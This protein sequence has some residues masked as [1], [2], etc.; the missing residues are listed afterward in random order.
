MYN[1]R[2]IHLF[3]TSFFVKK[4][5]YKLFYLTTYFCLFISYCNSQT[6]KKEENIFDSQ[7]E[8]IASLFKR[9]DNI[10]Y[11][12]AI[13]LLKKHQLE[14]EKSKDTSKILIF[15]RHA[16]DVFNLNYDYDYPKKYLKKGFE[17]LEHYDDKK[18]LGLFYELYGISIISGAEINKKINAY[19]VAEKLLCK[20][21]EPTDNIDINFNLSLSFKKIKQ[22][23]KVIIYSNKALLN[24]QKSKEKLNR[25][26]YLYFYLIEAYLEKKDYKNAKYYLDLVTADKALFLNDERL[27]VTYNEMLGKYF[28]FRGD[29]I[30]AAK[31]YD[32][33]I[34]ARNI[35][36]IKTRDKIAKSQLFKLNFEKQQL[37][38]KRIIKENQLNKTNLKYKNY[39]IT[40]GIITI[41]I[42]IVLLIFIYRNSLFKSRVNALLLENNNKLVNANAEIKNAVKIKRNFLDTITHELRTPLNTIKVI[43][44]LL[45][46][47]NE[48]VKKDEYLKS[49]NF[50]SDYLLSL[51]N[52]IIDYNILQNTE[53]LKLNLQESNLKDLMLNIEKSYSIKKENSNKLVFEIDDKIAPKLMIDNFRLIQVLMNLI[54]NAVKF[55][56]NGNV[57]VRAIL[58]NET[59]TISTIKFEVQD[60]GIGIEDAVKHTIFDVFEQGSK[61]INREYGGSGLGLSFVKKNIELY[62]SKIEVESEVNNGSKFTFIIKFNKVITSI[63]ATVDFKKIDNNKLFGQIKILLVEDNKVN[64]ML[65]KKIIERKGYICDVANNGLEAVNITK[66]NNYSLILMDIMM[67][68]MDGFE[69]SIKIKKS[70]PQIPIIALTAVSEEVNKDKFIKAGIKKVLTK[71]VDVE[72]LY[73]TILSIINK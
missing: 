57:Y 38:N 33:S 2:R 48:I 9:N 41:F 17:I 11:K 58:V 26:K 73:N 53:S 25:K 70:K 56:N 15:Y 69:A 10:S 7:F 4:K 39:I 63:G 30:N 62:D 55:T 40:L 23:D 42:L 65:T 37:I 36:D 27:L 68:V 47:E 19:L 18:E 22:W 71:P 61:K 35:Y 60:D 34:S 72:L 13:S 49:L 29:Y 5:K 28:L 14:I 6:Q 67:P 44:Y 45:T 52:N 46:E 3:I 20:Y 64:Q 54:D 24:I 31:F 51:I 1:F 12:K 43:S 50:S 16:I 8:E 66:S 59:E 21:G 32:E